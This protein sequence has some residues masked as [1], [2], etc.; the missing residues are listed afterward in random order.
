[1]DQVCGSIMFAHGLGLCF[2]G[3]NWKQVFGQAC[4]MNM[5]TDKNF[6]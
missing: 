4:W 5:I 2:T 6:V 3:V 1:M